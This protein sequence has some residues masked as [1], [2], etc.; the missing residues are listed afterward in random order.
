MF[1][2]NKTIEK[3]SNRALP[4][5]TVYRHREKLKKLP[6]SFLDIILLPRKRKAVDSPVKTKKK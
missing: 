6:D 1:N 4:G 3:E 5:S 2:N